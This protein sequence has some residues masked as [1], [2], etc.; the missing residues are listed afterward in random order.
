MN[1]KN[2]PSV[3]ENRIQ[4]GEAKKH[5]RAYDFLCRARD[6]VF[7]VP[8]IAAAFVPSLLLM[9]LIVLES[10]G[11]SP[12]FVQTRVGKDGKLFRMLKFRSM[13]SGA[14]TQLEELL[15]QN[16]MDGPAF[17]IKED[18]RITRI[19]KFIRKT[20]IDELP[21]FLNILCGQMTLIGPRPAL[22]REVEQYDDYE[23]Q[24]LQVRP[25]LTCLWQVTPDRNALEFSEWLEMDLRYIRERS[26]RLDIKILLLTVVAAVKGYGE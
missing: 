24:R 3:H 1:T 15:D 19:G 18:P 8:A 2:N 12:L 14:E 10:P 11:A 5:D 26:I 17:K 7:S 4:N 13:R 23:R 25:G 6:I 20:G 22:P 16:E 9:L 21:Q